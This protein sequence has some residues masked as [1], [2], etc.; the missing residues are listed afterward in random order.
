MGI[1]MDKPPGEM[2]L[3]ALADCCMG[4]VNKYRRG[5]P[6]D[7]AY[8]LE[9]FRR[10]MLQHDD[11]A[12]A[13][14]HQRFHETML[15]WIRRHPGGTLACQLESEQYYVDRAFQRFWQATTHNQRLEFNTLGAAL[16]YLKTSLNGE[17]M[18]VLRSHKRAREV[19]LPDVGFS[20]HSQWQEKE[21]FHQE[22]GF[23]EPLANEPDESSELW[24][25]IESLLPGE[26]ERRVAY[27]LYHCNLKP[28]EIVRYVPEEF[29]DVQ[30]VYRLSRNIYDRLMRNRDL[31]RWRLGSHESDL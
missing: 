4:E 24:E 28:R 6:H 10:A 22:G 30:E 16:Y 11:H 7:D 1:Q 29:G 17:I 2:R 8:C 13:I 23:V 21:T 27:L 3:D 15:S 25:A 26:R 31:L 5:E 9:V 20:E 12:W 19:P 18:D 14:L